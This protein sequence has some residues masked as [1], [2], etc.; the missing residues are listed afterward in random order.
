MAMQPQK[1]RTVGQVCVGGTLNNIFSK[2]V[3]LSKSAD[4][5]YKIIPNPLQI[6]KPNPLSQRFE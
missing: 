1:G 5:S 2:Q 4:S 6:N 3:V